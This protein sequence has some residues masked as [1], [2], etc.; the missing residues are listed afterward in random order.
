MKPCPLDGS[1]CEAHAGAIHGR[2]A[3][4]LRSGIEKILQSGLSGLRIRTQLQK[5]LD[6]T[7]ARDSLAFVEVE[8]EAKACVYTEAEAAAAIAKLPKGSLYGKKEYAKRAKRAKREKRDAPLKCWIC[9]KW[10]RRDPGKGGCRPYVK[11][12]ARPH[13][14]L[15]KACSAKLQGKK[16]RRSPYDPFR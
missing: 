16:R 12:A 14:D 7:D 15:C 13:A 5:L 11:R 8:E 3:E 2:E 6:D 4:K 1:P 10:M 9:R